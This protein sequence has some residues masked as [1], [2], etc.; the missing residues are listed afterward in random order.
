MAIESEINKILSDDAL[1]D[2][3]REEGK[4]ELIEAL[5]PRYGWQS[6]QSAII[7]VLEDKDR[8][9][10]DYLIAAELFWGA[11]LDERDI[12][13]DKVIALLTYRLEPDAGSTENNLAWSIA[14][15]LKGVGYMSD[16]EP[17][18]DA[19]VMVA[20]ENIKKAE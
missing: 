19:A 20:L 8:R 7:A 6:V 5:I 12:Q 18:K 11:T 4:S 16:Y 3:D 10:D 2:D 17:L 15:K 1:N 14:S 9:Q 13:I